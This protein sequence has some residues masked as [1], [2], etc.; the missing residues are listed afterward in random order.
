MATLVAVAGIIIATVALVAFVAAA[1]A[2][3]AGGPAFLKH[4]ASPLT[5][6]SFCPT[7]GINADNAAVYLALPNVIAV[8]GSWFVNADRIRNRG[9]AE[10]TNDVSDIV[11]RFGST[12]IL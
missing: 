6:I 1:S 8:G 11:R 5:D 10:I 4:I 3:A 7:G 2:G 9:W 12:K